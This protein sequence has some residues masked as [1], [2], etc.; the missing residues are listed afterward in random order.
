MRGAAFFDLDKTLVRVNT[1]PRYVR[2][3]VRQRQM[4]V[5]DLARVSWWSLQYTFGVLDAERISRAAA[6][7]LAGVDEAVFRAECARWVKEEIVEHVSQAARAE[8]DRRKSEGMTCALLTTSSPYVADPV[9]ENVGV[10]HVLCSRVQ[11][12]EG[13][14]TGRLEE[15]LCFGRGKVELA[16]R[17]AEAHDVDLGQSVFYTDSVTDLPMLER[18]GEPRVVNPD[19]RLERVARRRGWKIESWT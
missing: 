18:V 19:P 5:T 12:R 11:V 17:W 2:W 4:G 16:L 14:F 1:G 6:T 15:P 13:R 7:T 10:S 9:A 3:R 8:V